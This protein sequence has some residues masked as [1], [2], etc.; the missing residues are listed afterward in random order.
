MDKLESV[1]EDRMKKIKPDALQY[2][3]KLGWMPK[4]Q[5]TGPIPLSFST[6]NLE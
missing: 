2:D 6:P 1:D 5:I 4:S 3:I